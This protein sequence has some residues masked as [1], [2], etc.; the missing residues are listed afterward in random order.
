M[1]SC[2]VTCVHV[3]TSVAA[4]SYPAGSTYGYGPS[5]PTVASL[6]PTTAVSGGG[7]T[8]VTLTGTGFAYEMYVTARLGATVL[9]L[10]A[11]ITSATSATIAFPRNAGIGAWQVRA[12]NAAGA[13]PVARTFTLT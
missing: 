10:T 4:G 1:Q 6:A 2:S 12:E 7:T 11:T 3:D 9:T 5:P 8:T 13:S